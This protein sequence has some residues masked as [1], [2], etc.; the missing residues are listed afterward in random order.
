[1]EARFHTN[2][3]CEVKSSEFTSPEMWS[4]EKY[5]VNRDETPISHSSLCVS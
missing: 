4:V 3:H 1:M 2:I 5:F